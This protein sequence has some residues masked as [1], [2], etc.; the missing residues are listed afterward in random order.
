MK[1]KERRLKVETEDG[2]KGR[3][4]RRAQ[5]SSVIIT[6]F[7]TIIYFSLTVPFFNSR[8]R[9]LRRWTS[10]RDN[11]ITSGGSD[12]IR[13]V[14]RKSGFFG[15]TIRGKIDTAAASTNRFTRPKFR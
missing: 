5:A 15:G 7:T 13:Y 8:N 12:S 6:V 2:P 4:S 11:A 9:F 10:S 1:T 14:K 3:K